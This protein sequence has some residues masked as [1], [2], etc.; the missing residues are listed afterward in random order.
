MRITNPIPLTLNS[1]STFKLVENP[2]TLVNVKIV[3]SNPKVSQTITFY[4]Q[5]GTVE[6]VPL[7]INNSVEF[8]LENVNYSKITF[9]DPNNYTIFATMQTIIYDTQEEYNQ[10]KSSAD[11][12]LIPINNSIIVSPLDSNGYV[13]VDLETPLP[14]G[15]NTIGNVN[16]N[17]GSNAIGTVGV[18]SYGNPTRVTRTF[19]YLTASLT[20]ANTP[21]QITTTS[22][23][24]RKA[25]ITNTSASDTI[26]IGASTPSI[27]IA[28]NYTFVLEMNGDID[29][30]DLSTIY[31]VGATAGDSIKVIYL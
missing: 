23:L 27:P 18:T 15:S 17:A 26:Y 30:T 6:G 1:T 5:S 4:N 14:S 22:T 19:S 8:K 28:P 16:L 9:S 29:Q 21:Q 11:F 31:F 7:N 3:I 2:L 20:T 12:S 25:F 13:Q 10:A 24:V